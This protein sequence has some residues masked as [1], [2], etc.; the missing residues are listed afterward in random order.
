MPRVNVVANPLVSPDPLPICTAT[1]DT[2]GC[3]AVEVICPRLIRL[4]PGFVW[5]DTTPMVMF[6]TSEPTVGATIRAGEAPMVLSTAADVL[7]ALLN[8]PPFK[9]P[10]PIFPPNA[11]AQPGENIELLIAALTLVGGVVWIVPALM[12]APSIG[13]VARMPL[14]TLPCAVM[15]PACK[16]FPFS[17]DWMPIALAPKPATVSVDPALVTISP[18]NGAIC[19]NARSVTPD[20]VVG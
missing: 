13:A 3:T 5:S 17:S 16:R 20:A 9:M 6:P 8:G 14:E 10:P 15:V 2:P 1:G 7:S 19:R 11:A 4:Y 12:N 18:V